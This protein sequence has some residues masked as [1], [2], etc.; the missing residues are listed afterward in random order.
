MTKKLIALLFCLFIHSALAEPVPPLINYQG[1]LT[2]SE[3]KPLANGT[4]KLT[5]NIY[6]EAGVKKWGP[7]VFPSVPIIN[8]Y[9]NVI[10]GPVKTDANGVPD[11]NS[12]SILDAFNSSNRFLGITV[13]N[14]V[15]IMPRQQILSTPYAI[16]AEKAGNGIPIG[17]VISSLLTEVQVNTDTDDTNEV[18]VRKRKWVLA[19]GKDVSGS[20]YAQ[21]TGNSHIPDFRGVFLRG[22]NNGRNDG[23]ENPDGDLA[24]GIYQA[25]IFAEHTHSTVQM[26][27]NNNI[28]GVDIP[29]TIEDA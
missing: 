10:L 1:M 2:D 12:L 29:K 8:G 20:A 28:D 9:F 25:D 7:Q 6:D 3:G 5:F 15:E 11:Q 17:T 14:G 4:K 21:V 27:G 16:K 22:K 18:D 26:I 19:D 23:N 13:D 24:L